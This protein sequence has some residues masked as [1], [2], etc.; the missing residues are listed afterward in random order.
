M[1]TSNITTATKVGN[2]EVKQEI[3]EKSVIGS[4]VFDKEIHA[5]SMDRLGLICK[6][7]RRYDLIKKKMLNFSCSLKN[8]L[9]LFIPQEPSYNDLVLYSDL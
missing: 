4:K 8:S 3:I 1:N 7:I 9:I 5:E 2:V 6:K